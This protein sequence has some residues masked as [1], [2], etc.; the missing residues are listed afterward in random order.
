MREC[1]LCCRKRLIMSKT[2][3]WSL[4]KQHVRQPYVSHTGY[5]HTHTITTRHP[6]GDLITNS[7]TNTRHKCTQNHLWLLHSYT[8]IFIAR[9]PGLRETV[10]WHFVILNDLGSDL[11]DD[12]SPLRLLVDRKKD[13]IP[14][15]HSAMTTNHQFFLNV[16][17]CRQGPFK[18]GPFYITFVNG[19]T[20]LCGKWCSGTISHTWEV[21]NSKLLF[22]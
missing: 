7:H 3:I 6:S 21:I 19:C 1:V 2:S 20:C 4:S 13:S 16:C 8:Y 9:A 11:T 22:Y 18:Y 14:K 5:T 10:S 15:T 12:L 17:V